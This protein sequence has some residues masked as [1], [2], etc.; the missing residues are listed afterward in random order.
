MYEH[1]APPHDTNALEMLA[2]L[3]D[4][5]LLHL[6]NCSACRAAWYRAGAW[7]PSCTDPRLGA[8]LSLALGSPESA[9]ARVLVHVSECVACA[10]ESRRWEFFAT[11]RG[12]PSSA[13]L[14]SVLS[15]TRRC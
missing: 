13:L 15:R 3:S 11:S 8:A 7:K 12:V 1:L 10:I 5:A 2:G 6:R 4:A 9:P 14:R